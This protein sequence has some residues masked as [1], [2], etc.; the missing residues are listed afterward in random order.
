MAYRDDIKSAL[1]KPPDNY[2]KL[3]EI[4]TIVR[5]IRYK[6]GEGFAESSVRDQIERNSSDSQFWRGIRD[7][8]YSVDGLRQGVW[9]LRPDDGPLPVCGAE[10]DGL[11]LGR[12][13]EGENHRRLRLCVA[14]HPHKLFDDLG[15]VESKTE[16]DLPSGDR[17]DVIYNLKRKNI[18]IAIEVKSR[19][20]NEA[21]IKRGIYQCVKYHAVLGAVEYSLRSIKVY[22][23]T[24][25]PVQGNLAKLAKRLKIDI[26]TVAREWVQNYQGPA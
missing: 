10:H 11:G 3:E 6:R 4:Y 21:D 19:D 14:K 8:F 5:D 2:G 22:L 26:V 16:Y 17:V 15:R 7:W 24:E 25:T 23:V 9:G 12:S 18:I 13:G 20:S 1:Q